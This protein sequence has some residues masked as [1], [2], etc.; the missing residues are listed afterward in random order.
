LKDHAHYFAEEMKKHQ[1]IKSVCRYTDIPGIPI[2]D[3]GFVVAG[4]DPSEVFVL[5]TT[6]VD[7]AYFKI[8][9]HTWQAPTRNPADSLKYE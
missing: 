7:S 2:S 5:Y 3:N 9:Y 8:G 6:W 1:R 4:K